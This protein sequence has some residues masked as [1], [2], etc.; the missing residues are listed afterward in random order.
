MRDLA[1]SVLAGPFTGG[2]A[3]GAGRVGVLGGVAEVC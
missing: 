1:A 2:L 3:G